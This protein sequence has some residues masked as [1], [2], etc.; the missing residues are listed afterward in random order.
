MTEVTTSQM[1]DHSRVWIYQADRALSDQEVTEIEQALDQ[2]VSQWAA[3]QMPL[4]AGGKVI[5]NRFLVLM[6]DEKL[7]G[8]SG[9]SIDASVHFVQRLGSSLGIDFFGRLQFL[10]LDGEQIKS[11]HKSRLKA[12]KMEGAINDDTVFYDTLINTKGEL[13]RAFLK[14]LKSSWHGRLL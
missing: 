2:F 10:Y 12:A 11:V 7:Q 9:C 14:P 1:A 13:D 3:H 5:N 8:A 6:V 4:T